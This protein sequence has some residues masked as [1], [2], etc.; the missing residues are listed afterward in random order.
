MI[1]E[2]IHVVRIEGRGKYQAL[3]TPKVIRI[4]TYPQYSTRM[5]NNHNKNKTNI[6]QIVKQ[7]KKI[8]IQ[9]QI[10]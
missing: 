4:T 10:N 9:K 5:I 3:G 2:V 1:N 7:I 8:H 6:K